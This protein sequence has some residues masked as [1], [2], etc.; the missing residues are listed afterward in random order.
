MLVGS[1]TSSKTST[2]GIR[3]KH[4]PVIGRDLYGRKVVGDALRYTL[5]THMIAEDFDN[6]LYFYRSGAMQRAQ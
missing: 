4:T 6:I 2:F 3:V 1:S 5:K